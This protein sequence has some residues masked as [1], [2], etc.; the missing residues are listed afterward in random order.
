MCIALKWF[1]S[2]VHYLGFSLS[3]HVRE[4]LPFAN[5]LGF[6]VEEYAGNK[7]TLPPRS[8][9]CSLVSW[10]QLFVFV[11]LCSFYLLWIKKLGRKRR[12]KNVVYIA[13]IEKANSLTNSLI[14]LQKVSELGLCIIDEV[15]WRG[16]PRLPLVGIIS[17][18][19]CLLWCCC[20]FCF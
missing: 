16:C 5:E 2:L 1:S 8:V 3:K 13:T 9:S 12:K 4:L 11:F 20:C 19:L 14:E 17:S 6:V 15:R 18:A 7:G 10:I